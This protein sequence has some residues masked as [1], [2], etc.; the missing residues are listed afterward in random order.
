MLFIY[1]II[2]KN[3]S[4]LK[5]LLPPPL[6]FV[7]V[8]QNC[9]RLSLENSLLTASTPR[10]SFKIFSVLLFWLVQRHW[11]EYAWFYSYQHT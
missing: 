8:S 4:S 7:V 1:Q 9:L 11:A 2:Q 5:R 6:L 10:V 3:K